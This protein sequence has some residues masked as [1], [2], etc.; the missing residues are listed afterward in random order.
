M[1]RTLFPVK[2]V[3]G[4]P[5]VLE[6]SWVVKLPNGRTCSIVTSTKTNEFDERQYRLH[7]HEGITRGS[8]YWLP[9]ITCDRL[10]TRDELQEQGLILVY[11]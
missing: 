3:I 11:E 9:A 5:V 6:A 7:Y 2:Q 1:A 10:Y 4:L 8:D